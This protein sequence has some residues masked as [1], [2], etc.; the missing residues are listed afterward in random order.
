ME[1]VMYDLLKLSKNTREESE[2]NLSKVQD[3]L[4]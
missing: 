4:Q 2:N 1:S 3:E